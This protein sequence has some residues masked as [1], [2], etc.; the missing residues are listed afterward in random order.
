MFH[1]IFNQSSI[2]NKNDDVLHWLFCHGTKRE[3][4]RIEKRFIFYCLHHVHLSSH[5]YFYCTRVFKKF[6]FQSVHWTTRICVCTTNFRHI[7]IL[8]TIVHT[9]TII[10]P[11]EK[12]ENLKKKNNINRML[13]QLLF[14]VLTKLT[15]WTR[16][17]M[18]RS[19]QENEL[20]KYPLNLIISHS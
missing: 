17:C 9:S 1:K 16:K 4:S 7:L 3:L 19:E 10:V 13:L 14:F 5:L 20:M 15:H 6:K 18:R 12:K 2:E 8:R 11:K